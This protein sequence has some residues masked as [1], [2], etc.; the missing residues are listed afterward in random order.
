[1]IRSPTSAGDRGEGGNK[2]S[3]LVVLCMLVSRRIYPVL[4]LKLGCH[5]TM[6]LASE[7]EV[8]WEIH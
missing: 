6:N 1:V 4:K 5:V 7:K 8:M 3:V 2:F